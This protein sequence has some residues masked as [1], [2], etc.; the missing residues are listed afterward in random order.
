MHPGTQG[1]GGVEWQDPVNLANVR[2][3]SLPVTGRGG[4]GNF[5]KVKKAQ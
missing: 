4:S 1:G 3:P 5:K 2:V